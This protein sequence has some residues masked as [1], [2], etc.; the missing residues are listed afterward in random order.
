MIE[1]VVYLLEAS[2]NVT[3]A[4]AWCADRAVG[5]KADFL[6]CVEAAVLT[7]PRHTQMHPVVVDDFYHALTR[8]FPFEIFHKPVRGPSRIF[9]C[10]IVGL[11]HKNAGTDSATDDGVGLPTS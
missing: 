8:R 6:G 3:Q 9:P 5:P 11:I 1:R 10:S 4:H 7:I 2:S